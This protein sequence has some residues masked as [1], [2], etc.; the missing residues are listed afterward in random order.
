MADERPNPAS[1]GA[2]VPE[3]DLL[4]AALR[5]PEAAGLPLTL[6]VC[7]AQGTVSIGRLRQLAP[8]TV[9]RLDT[10]LGEPARLL[11]EGRPIARGELAERR[12]TLTLRI[13]AFGDAD[14]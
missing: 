7:L 4:T 10:E 1:P 9:V 11:A 8:G 5:R 13:G 2:G 6:S 12:G 14:D 3:V